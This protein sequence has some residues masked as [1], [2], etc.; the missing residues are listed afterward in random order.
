MTCKKYLLQGI[1]I[2]PDVVYVCKRSKADLIEVDDEPKTAD[3]WWRLAYTHENEA[4][5]V[6]AEVGILTEVATT[7]LT[8]HI[9]TGF[10]PGPRARVAGYQDTSFDICLGT[11]SLCRSRS[12]VGVPGA[13]Y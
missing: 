11:G 8:A 7:I 9:A 3:Q 4:E 10:Q 2:S 5:P 13:V 6:K 12:A 1:V